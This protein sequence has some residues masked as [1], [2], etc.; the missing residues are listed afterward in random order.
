M[1]V[2]PL[3]TLVISIGLAV[4][5]QAPAAHAQS[6][7]TQ[8]DAKKAETHFRQ[9]VKLYEEGDFRG[10]LVEFRRSYEAAA[11]PGLL[12]N[13]AQA[14]YQLNDYAGALGT[15]D[16]YLR[17]AG[18]SVPAARRA[19]VEREIRTLTER[20]GRLQVESSEPGAEVFVDGEL[21]GTT[22][23]ASAVLVSTGSRSIRVT[24]A[25]FAAAE[26]RVDIASGE[27]SSLRFDLTSL[28]VQAA[29][30][31]PPRPF[32]WIPWAVTGVLLGGT[33]GTGVAALSASNRLSSMR[34]QV[35]PSATELQS[36]ADTAKALSITTDVL[37]GATLI[38]A[39]VALYITI[40]PHTPSK[41]QKPESAPE[42]TTALG[43]LPGGLSLSR[44]F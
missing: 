31:A 1:R 32:P 33:V 26:R 30:Q 13:I 19:E 28:V 20:T 12:Y 27:T 35:S 41:D 42:G 4:V 3:T 15:L 9:G 6:A 34:D 22:P 17:E 44:T 14:Q 43:V 23:L 2:M 10:A 29:S 5:A 39:G 8:Q 18:A 21:V 38:S 24:K 25:G 40:K 16:R 11:N 7:S 36:R 37:L